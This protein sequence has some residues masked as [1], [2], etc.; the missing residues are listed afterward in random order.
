[1]AVAVRHKE[2]RQPSARRPPVRQVRRDLLKMGGKRLQ[3]RLQ[4]LVIGPRPVAFAAGMRPPARWVRQHQAYR[5]GMPVLG[6]AQQLLGGR[7]RQ[8]VFAAVT[9][10]LADV[11]GQLAQ[12]QALLLLSALAQQVADIEQ[13]Q[14]P[15]D[16][17]V[18]QPA[19][20]LQGLAVH[21]VKIQVQCLPL[22]IGGHTFEGQPAVP[23]QVVVHPRL[24]VA[25]YGQ[26][27]AQGP[28][29]A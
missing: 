18:L 29:Q 16:S 22:P 25:G 26:Q 2:Q 17:L 19:T 13:L 11:C 3:P 8:P 14:H 28:G 6:Q 7:L 12:G 20:G 23:I 24:R 21:G 10:G 5:A 15:A 4:A 1:M 27:R 9:H